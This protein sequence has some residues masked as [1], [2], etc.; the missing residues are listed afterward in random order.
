MEANIPTYTFLNTIT[1][2]EWT[3]VMTISA[4]EEL[5]KQTHIV[6]QFVKAPTLGYHM[7]SL[8][9]NTDFRYKLNQIK[10]AHPGSTV[11]DI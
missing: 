5:T 1:N 4:M 6:Q 9:P 7:T 10:K 11:N 3:E 2:E 8:K